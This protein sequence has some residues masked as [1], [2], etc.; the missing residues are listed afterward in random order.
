MSW[1]INKKRLIDWCEALESRSFKQLRHQVVAGFQGDGKI[2]HC[3]SATG[4]LL[5]INDPGPS[6]AP[7]HWMCYVDEGCQVEGVP[8][9]VLKQVSD[10]NDQRGGLPHANAAKKLREIIEALD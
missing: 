9:W 7:F 6:K 8:D 4:V 3:Y 2:E 10:A 5:K 1:D